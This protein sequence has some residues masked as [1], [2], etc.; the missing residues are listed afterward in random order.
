[1]LA[2]VIMVLYVDVQLLCH[3]AY[4]MVLLTECMVKDEASDL[5]VKTEPASV[6]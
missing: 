2:Q 5:A 6:T 4:A 3:G 1:M